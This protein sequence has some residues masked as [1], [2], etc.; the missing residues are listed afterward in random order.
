MEPGITF[1]MAGLGGWRGFAIRPMRT[2]VEKGCPPVEVA[3]G[4]E[5]TEV[6]PDGLFGLL[7]SVSCGAFVLATDQT[8]V[9][10]NRRAREILGYA[11][12][13]VI[14]RRCSAVAFG[15]LGVTLSE[16]CEEGCLMVR[17]LRA[18]LVPGRARMRM[19][20]SWGEWK[21]L[22]V[23]PMVV[24]GVEEGGP[25][26]VYLFGDS[27]EAAVSVDV[28]RL[29]EL[30]AREGRLT[31]RPHEMGEELRELY[32]LGAE[33]DAGE[34]RVVDPRQEGLEGLGTEPGREAVGSGDR[35][36]GYA[37]AEP[38]PLL[39][40]VGSGS[41]YPGFN[42]DQP[43][44]RPPNLIP[45]SSPEA[46]LARAASRARAANLTPRELEV[47]SYVA[48][49]WETKYIADE[50]GI[51]WYTARNH[52]ENLRR[53]LGAANRLEAVMEAMRLGIIQAE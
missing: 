20:C 47:L 51:S 24:A 29:A 17:N 33:L 16:G 40:D 52:V 46:L 23:T 39:D 14:G 8:V 48:L 13:R 28:A 44:S 19:R 35:D 22:V 30:G 37:S 21:W 31:K 25:L 49:G 38:G 27:D 45:D 36:R 2:D 11:P 43:S 32:E 1:L 26:L 15:M 41:G 3:G 6:T 53:K 5:I 18:G 4:R 34:G 12:D 7:S 10:W 42:D 50:L 9:F